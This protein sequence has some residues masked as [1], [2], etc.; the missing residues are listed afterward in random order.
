MELK[1]FKK[2]KNVTI[3]EG[4]PGIGFVGS[5]TTEFLIEHLQAEKIGSIVSE[6]M[7]P[8]T[9]IHN[10]KVIEPFGIFYNKKYNLVILQTLNPVQKL[11]WKAANVLTDLIKELTAKEIISLEGVASPVEEQNVYYYSKKSSKKFESI[12]IS[13]LK[14][15]II[16][17]VTASLL[18]KE[19]L[20]LTCIFVE[21]HSNLP[22]SR[23]AAKLIEALDKY[24][25]LQVDYKPLLEKAEHFEKKIKSIISKSQEATDVRD[26]KELDYFG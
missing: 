21:T 17:G 24:L 11:E 2:P 4:F 9:V 12:K 26:N 18:L 3:I 22:D 14:D 10:S 8:I 5:I 7:M 1:L 16:L 13:P 19:K 23:G 15:G 25:G 6:D 20:P